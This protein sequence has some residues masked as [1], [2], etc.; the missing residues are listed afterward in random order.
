MEIQLLDGGMGQE[1][2]RRSS[3]P[4]TPLWSALM[5]L[6]EPDLVEQLHLEF[7][8]AGARVVTLNSYAVT[9]PRLTL[10]GAG[11]S[12][13][14][15]QEAAVCAA[16]R[17]RQRSGRPDVAIAGCLPPLVA[18]YRSDVVPSY[19]DCLAEYRRMVAAQ[20]AG[21]DLFLCETLTRAREVRAAVGAAHESG[22][23][24][25]CALTVDDADGSRARSGQSLGELA[26]VAAEAGAQALLINCSTPEATTTALKTLRGCGLTLGAYAN[27]FTSVEAL[28]PGGT[29]EVL[30]ARKDLGPGSYARH[31]LDW[32]EEGASIIGGCCEIGPTH[33]AELARQLTAA[34]HSI[35]AP[36][37]AAG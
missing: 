23:P 33:I 5:L 20:D 4:L 30:E 32:V 8:E 19:E 29:V 13:S 37:K 7:I 35:S 9:G 17:A 16:L 3:L 14:A 6:E 1:L 15:M 36:L 11:E 25:W 26:T 21:V 12:F 34:G 24:V 27:G 28:E 10:E 22:R 18:S 31:A 2:T